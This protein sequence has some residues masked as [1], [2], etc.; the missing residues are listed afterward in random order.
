MGSMYVAAAG[1]RFLGLLA[2]TGGMLRPGEEEVDEEREEDDEEE[3]EEREE[4]LEVSIRGGSFPP[5][6]WKRMSIMTF[7]GPETNR[8]NL[9]EKYRGVKSP[10][11]L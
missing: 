7:D 4:Q 10:N 5:R 11:H 8:P 6:P 9:E 1:I 2:V 3:E